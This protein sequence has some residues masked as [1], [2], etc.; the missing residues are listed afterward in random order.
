MRS[1]GPPSAVVPSRRGET[2]ETAGC[3]YADVVTGSNAFAHDDHP[4]WII[5]AANE[6][7]SPDG[8]LCLEF[9][10]AGGLRGQLQW[11]TLYH[12]HLTFY[13]LSTISKLLERYGFYVNESER[14]PMHSGS[15]RVCAGRRP[16]PLEPGAARILRNEE[17]SGLNC[18]NTWTRFAEDPRRKIRIVA[19]VFR[20]ISATSPRK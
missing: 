12:E 6:V 14:L 19:D 5:E 10:Y 9:M 17:E 20:A 13:S 18:L 2:A 7:L 16:R 11:D 4:E 15:L 3:G 1:T 8:W